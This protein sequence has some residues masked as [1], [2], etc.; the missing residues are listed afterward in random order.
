MESLKSLTT[1]NTVAVTETG[2]VVMRSGSP[3]PIASIATQHGDV[4]VVGRNGAGAED[5]LSIAMHMVGE[6]C[7]AFGKP[8]TEEDAL[9]LDTLRA[10]YACLLTARAKLITSAGLEPDVL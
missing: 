2:Y 9:R 4:N 6:Q 7:D 10:A 3:K 1:Q 8:E 5:V